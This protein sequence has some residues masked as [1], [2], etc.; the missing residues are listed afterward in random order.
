MDTIPEY[1]HALNILKTIPPILLTFGTI[2]NLLTILVLSRKRS[3]FSS[4][5]T[6]LAALAVS[7]LLVLYSGLLRQW[8]KYMY[9]VDI[10]QLTVAGCKVNIFLVYFSTQCSSWLLVAVTCERFIG[11]WLPH[12]VKQGCTQRT[13]LLVIGVIVV[14]ITLLNAHFFYGFGNISYVVNGTAREVMC[15]TKYTHYYNFVTLT[16]PWID[17]CFFFLVPFTV[18]VM[19]NISIIARVCM[20]KYKIRN[21]IVPSGLTTRQTQKDKTSHLTAM[22]MTLNVVFFICVSPICIFFISRPYWLKYIKT[23]YDTAIVM[24]WWAV[25]NCFMYLNNTLNFVLYFL[26]GSRFREETKMLFCGERKVA[27]SQDE[28]PVVANPAT[29][30]GSG[31]GNGTPR[32]V[33]QNVVTFRVEA[34]EEDRNYDMFVIAKY[35]LLRQSTFPPPLAVSDLLVLY[36]GLLRMWLRSSFGEDVSQLPI[37]GCKHPNFDWL[38]IAVTC[39]KLKGVWM[40][41]RVKQGCIRKTGVL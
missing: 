24:L 6:Y 40:Q 33:H 17:L 11:V 1:R 34:M 20:S 21:Q 23:P 13:A 14:C 15:S 5:A 36:F 10:R 4:T 32:T 39:E 12:R 30:Q 7:D 29:R 31:T 9:D 3:R 8:M 35:I 37:A 41:H 16:W 2:G 18:L 38:L 26:S 19:G 25:I 27:S 22:L 28:T